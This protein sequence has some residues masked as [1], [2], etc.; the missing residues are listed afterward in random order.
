MALIIIQLFS[1]VLLSLLGYLIVKK[2]DYSL[3]SGFSSK[4]VEEQQMLIKNGYPQ[5][6]GK[7]MWYS[8]IIL[9]IGLVLY[10]LNIPYMIEISWIVMILFL[11][12]YLLYIQKLDTSKNRKTNTL[13]LVI[14][15]VTTF[16]IIAGVFYI[17]FQQNH[18]TISEEQFQVSGF[19]G[20]T[21]ELDALTA[22]EL[23]DEI[24]DIEMRTNGFAM[25][26]RLKGNFRLEKLG[27]GKLF[28]YDNHPPYLYIKKGEDYL[29]INSKNV[30]ETVQWYEQ[31]EK[32]RESA[33]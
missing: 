23:V 16:F 22:I 19:Y 2:E 6:V 18:V 12:A 10:L 11:F 13:L 5:A 1:I 26:N 14:T 25:G 29:F 8:S 7:S 24:P 9:L 3:I 30:E 31:L 32:I 20:V 27:N 17:G 15:M 28:L 21:W 33:S 4:T